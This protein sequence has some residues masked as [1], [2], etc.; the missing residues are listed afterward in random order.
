M[1]R[2]GRRSLWDPECQSGSVLDEV[3]RSNQGSTF[4]SMGGDPS[5]YRRCSPSRPGFRDAWEVSPPPR[6]VA[7]F[8]LFPRG[9]LRAH[10]A[11]QSLTSYIGHL[12]LPSGRLV[13]IRWLQRQTHGRHVFD[14]DGPRREDA[15]SKVNLGWGQDDHGPTNQDDRRQRYH[16]TQQDQQAWVKP[17][18]IVVSDRG[19]KGGQHNQEQCRTQEHPALISSER[20][21]LQRLLGRV[22][23]PHHRGDRIASAGHYRKR[24]P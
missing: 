14:A 24:M 16:E 5:K 1:T 3:F 23:R 9:G 2:L 7:I 4:T 17:V 18:V 6:L 12:E 10:G 15:P 11:D 13:R 20:R 22:W 19:Q 8:A 21:N